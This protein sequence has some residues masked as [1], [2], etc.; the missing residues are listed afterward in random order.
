M[1]QND[2][3]SFNQK[4]ITQG[5]ARMYDSTFS[6]REVFVTAEATARQNCVG[7]WNYEASPTVTRTST[8]TSSQANADSVDLP[9]KPADGDY[10]CSHFDTHEQA[11][12]V[13]EQDTSDSH[14]LDGSDNDGKAC[15]S[16]P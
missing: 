9:P 5:Y 12:Y 1:N 16:L 6:K 7:L 15:E 4:L 10:D 14:R 13:Y 3:P 11:Q 2:G 8:P